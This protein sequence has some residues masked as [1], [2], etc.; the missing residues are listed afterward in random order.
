MGSTAACAV[1]VAKTD[2]AALIG[3]VKT[4]AE[5][6][7]KG[8]GTEIVKRLCAFFQNGGRQVYLCREENKNEL[9]YSRIGFENC[10]EWMTAK[11]E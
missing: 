4:A 8:I 11:N 7:N 2:K 9:F 10:G 1:C 3:F 6:R 5:Y